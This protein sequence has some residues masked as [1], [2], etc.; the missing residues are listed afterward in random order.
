MDNPKGLSKSTF[1]GELMIKV[2]I[3]KFIKHI[4][5]HQRDVAGTYPN[6]SNKIQSDGM[7]LISKKLGASEMEAMLVDL[8]VGYTK[9]F[10]S[11]KDK[12]ACVM[13]AIS[14]L[15]S[16]NVLGTATGYQAYLDIM[17]RIYQTDNNYRSIFHA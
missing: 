4:N 14:V 6:N 2:P 17:Y 3:A 7:A 1:Q 8:V 15:T 16:Q 11:A 9:N 10:N 13:A 5:N 12:I